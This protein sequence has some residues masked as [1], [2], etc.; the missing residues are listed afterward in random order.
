MIKRMVQL[1]I[2][3]GFWSQEP[4]GR[5]GLNLTTPLPTAAPTAHSLTNPNPP[6]SIHLKFS[7]ETGYSFIV[8]KCSWHKSEIVTMY[9]PSSYNSRD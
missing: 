8:G 5:V 6:Q 7:P 1:L 2:S 9:N 3:G 4:T